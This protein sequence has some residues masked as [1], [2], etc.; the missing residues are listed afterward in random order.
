TTPGLTVVPPKSIPIAVL[1]IARLLTI[2]IRD[3]AQ[4]F[5]RQIRVHRLDLWHSCSDQS[6]IA[7]S[8]NDSRLAATE[9]LLADPGQDFPNETALTKDGPGHHRSTRYSTHRTSTIGECQLG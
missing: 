2:Q 1:P 3:N 8:S 4:T 9:R 7:T 6:G 5:Q